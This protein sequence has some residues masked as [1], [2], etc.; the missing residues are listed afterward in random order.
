MLN[1]RASP[2]APWGTVATASR[3]SFA[4]FATALL[5][6]R[7]PHKLSPLSGHC[8]AWSSPSSRRGSRRSMASALLL[9]TKPGVAGKLL[10]SVGLL[11]ALPAPAFSA[12]CERR[13]CWLRRCQRTGLSRAHGAFC[14]S[15]R[16]LPQQRQTESPMPVPSSTSGC[17]GVRSPSPTAAVLGRRAGSGTPR[18]GTCP[19]TWH[20]R[21]GCSWQ[22]RKPPSAPSAARGPPSAP[23]GSTST[24]RSSR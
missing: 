13:A 12:P 10:R 18:A 19:G 9:S 3:L 2:T 8:R 21:R 4:T 7:V 6:L 20:G 24:P 5:A 17:T 11:A 16:P 23:C 14:Q 22:G 15:W 1:G